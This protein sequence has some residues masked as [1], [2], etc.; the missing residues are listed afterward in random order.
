MKLRCTS[1]LAVAI[2]LG[3]NAQSYQWSFG[4]GSAQP[5]LYDKC[6][7][8][9]ADDFG[10]VYIAGAIEGTTDFAPSSSGGNFFTNS[11]DGFLVKYNSSG[12]YQ[13]GVQIGGS[14][15]SV[16]T[17]YGVA[18]DASGSVYITGAISGTTDFD[19]ST[20][21]A[22]LTA[23]GA[24]IYVAKYDSS[25]V[26]QWA[27]LIGGSTGNGE[28][29]CISTDAANNVYVLASFN[30]TVD[31]DPSG[32]TTNISSVGAQDCFVAKYSSAGV[33]QLGFRFGGSQNDIPSV[34]DID[35]NGNIAVT[36]NFEGTADFDPG[37][38][39]VNRTSVGND[40]IF[41]AEYNSSGALMWANTFGS[42]LNDEGAGLVTDAAGN[43][44]ATGYFQ[45]TVDFDP[46]AGVV[47]LNGGGLFL[48]QYDNAGNYVSAFGIPVGAGKALAMDNWGNLYM[49]GRYALGTGDFDPGPGVATLTT[50]GTDIFIAKYDPAGN[51]VWAESGTSVS[52]GYAFGLAID[53]DPSGAV[54]AGG[55]FGGTY[56]FDPS[57]STG[58]EI[59]SGAS[60]L[61]I[62]KYSSCIGAPLQPSGI[63]GSSSV[64]VGDISSYSVSPVAGATNYTWTLP[65]GWSGNSSSNSIS[66]NAGANSGVVTVMA[67]N[68]CGSSAPESLLVNVNA[69]PVVIF[70][71]P[72]DT[73]CLNSAS[74]VLT[75][76]SPIGGSYFGS[77]VSAG[78]FDPVAL[79]SHVISYTYTDTNF[80]T[81]TAL[82]SIW[83]DACLG[84]S[85][86]LE[87]PEFSVFPSP[88][89]GWITIDCPLLN[90]RDATITVTNVYG[91]T[92]CSL[93]SQDPNTKI[94]ISQYPAGL[95]L[96]CVRSGNEVFSKAIVK[97]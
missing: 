21:T 15:F 16:E 93:R 42:T 46:G 48:A 45:D 40:D 41:I 23:N 25:G 38:G 3:L 90:E 22:N 83:V 86:Q 17:C 91:V 33:Y 54:F 1:I 43:V 32:A 49:T 9:S 81:N 62:A 58:S 27:F 11:T 29:K 19:P 69:L 65:M 71:V 31:V 35:A 13:W 84:M 60:D 94:D 24:D 76:G 68:A 44:Y 34:V 37:V 2:S 72:I 7:D 28:G 53:L 10:N 61:F 70:S 79:G 67:N 30:G 6:T 77:N 59:A 18:T 92:I 12:V 56:D 96:V 8:I 85:T 97:D 66:T 63:V 14:A 39:I 64:C 5:G 73:V 55:Y 36:G 26:Y 88:T 82:D 57:P 95:Y 50:T 78:S 74:V 47:N 20:G 87:E 80:C 51:Y 4:T 89:N 75:G 52:S